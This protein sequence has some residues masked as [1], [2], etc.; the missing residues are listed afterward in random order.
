MSLSKGIFC[1]IV[2]IFRRGGFSQI[3]VDDGVISVNP[4]L[5]LVKDADNAIAT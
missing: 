5:Q 1:K 4:P 3:V 2:S